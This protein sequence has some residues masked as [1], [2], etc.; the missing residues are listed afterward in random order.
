MSWEG[1]ARSTVSRDTIQLHS[2]D[3]MSALIRSGF[4]FIGTPAPFAHIELSS[5]S[6]E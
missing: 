6:V 1:Y 3:N 4:T 2:R 5:G